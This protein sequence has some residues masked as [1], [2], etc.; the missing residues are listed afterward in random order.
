MLGEVGWGLIVGGYEKDTPAALVYK[1]TWP[2]EKAFLCTV[3][4]LYATAEE[5]GITRTALVLVGEAVAHRR[6]QKSK[7][8]DPAFSTAFRTGREGDT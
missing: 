7:L 1:A 4:T 2:E 3:D 8:Y 6:Y 5:H